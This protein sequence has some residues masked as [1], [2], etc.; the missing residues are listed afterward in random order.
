M[1][2]EIQLQEGKKIYFASDFHFGI[3]NYEESRSR[4]K[5][6]CNW[7]DKI[8]ADAQFIFLLGD[9]FDSWMEYKKVVPKG[10]IR[11]LGKLA[12]LSDNG[13]KIIIFTGNH[14]AWVDD[15]FQ[16]EIGCVVYKTPQI[17]KIND[18]I[19]FIGHGDGLVQEEAKYI[20]MKK[21]IQHPWSQFLYR[22]IHPDLGLQIADYF[23]R[24]GVKHK[25]EESHIKNFENEY[26]IIFAKKFLKNNVVDFFIFGHRHIEA[27]FQLDIYTYFLNLG[28]WFI[29]D[30]YAEFDGEKVSLIK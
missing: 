11:F 3:P 22:Q 2:N 27:Y 6:V 30:I 15:Y 5:R 8:S 7:L 19:F 16:K 28:D 10:Y 1:S 13:I 29:N 14:D 21:I 20:R 17:F 12:E 4:E 18:K 26:Q 9:L 25:K 24:K 23:S